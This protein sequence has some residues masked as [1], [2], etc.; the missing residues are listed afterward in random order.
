MKYNLPR[1]PSQEELTVLN[2]NNQTIFE[3]I[4]AM[5]G[6][7]LYLGVFRTLRFG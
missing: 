5:R 2:G 1:Q 4:L 7:F 3:E 6:K